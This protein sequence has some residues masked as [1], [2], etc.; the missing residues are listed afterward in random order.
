ML[1]VAGTS[2]FCRLLGDKTEPSQSFSTLLTFTIPLKHRDIPLS[3]L[4]GL[5][6]PAPFPDLHTFLLG[7][8][9]P[10]G[11]PTSFLYFCLWSSDH[12]GARYRPSKR[13]VLVKMGSKN[14]KEPDYK[15]FHKTHPHKP[16]NITLLWIELLHLS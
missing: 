14:I 6:S 13:G 16:R 8:V 7:L 5:L 9:P 4:D 15:T 11:R 1:P 12:F 2:V 10:S 3:D